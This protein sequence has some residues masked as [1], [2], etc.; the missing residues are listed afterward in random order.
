MKKFLVMTVATFAVSAFAAG[1]V[2]TG[3]FPKLKSTST[4]SMGGTSSQ[5]QEQSSNSTAFASNG[6]NALTLEAQQTNQLDLEIAKVN[7]EAAARIAAINSGAKIKN[8]P[9]VSASPLTSSND[10]C[11][12]SASGAL[13]VPG[14]GIGLG[15]TYIDENCMML[16]NSRELW[17]MG[18][19]AASLAL[20]C[21]DANNRKALELT[22]FV[23]PQTEQERKQH[24]VPVAQEAQGSTS[25]YTGNDP[26][27]RSRLGLK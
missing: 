6:G 17:N 16:K 22:G 1:P 7:A 11:M 25:E 12:G 9:S 5:Q 10:T 18:M 15:K 14:F 13:N 19:K 23:C 24:L 2:S 8:T 4:L 3:P 20:M 21:N 27:V 26:I